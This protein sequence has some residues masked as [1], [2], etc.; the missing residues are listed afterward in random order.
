M[1]Q[2]LEVLLADVV[3]QVEGGGEVGLAA[4]LRAQQH[5][6]LQGMG[7]LVAPQR[8]PL[9]ELLLAHGARERRL[10]SG[11]VLKH[12]PP[13]LLGHLTVGFGAGVTFVSSFVSFPGYMRIKFHQAPVL[14]TLE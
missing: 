11:H 7:A 5:R 2:E 10:V 13:R 3:L 4:L 6:L 1:A 12:L 14:G 9:L 8:V